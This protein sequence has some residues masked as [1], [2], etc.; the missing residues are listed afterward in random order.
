M[1]ELWQITN[2][3]LNEG[4]DLLLRR[5]EGNLAENDAPR[6]LLLDHDSPGLA[7]LSESGA[8]RY[9]QCWRLAVGQMKSRA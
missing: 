8:V 3:G 5:R 1:E 2:L 9:D 4:E 7:G 6:V